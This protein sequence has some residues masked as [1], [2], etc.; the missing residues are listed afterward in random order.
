MSSQDFTAKQIEQYQQAFSL[1]DK[2]RDGTISIQ[3]LGDVMRALGQHPI[4]GELRDMINEVDENGT[5]S[6]TLLSSSVL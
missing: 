3:E 2:D 4:Q 6:L 1:F 5:E